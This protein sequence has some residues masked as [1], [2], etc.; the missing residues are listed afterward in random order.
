M[1]LT[2]FKARNH[3]QQVDPVSGP[4]LYGPRAGANDLI[5]DRATLPEWFAELH[6]R[7]SFT[8]DVAASASNTKLPRY[9]DIESNGLEQSWAGERVWCNPPFSDLKSWVAKASR[10]DADLIVMLVPANRT[11]Q[12][13]WHEHIE[14]FRDRPGSIL[15]TEF[16]RH[17]RRFI[18]QGMD[19]VLPNDRPPFGVCLLI[20]QRRQ[21]NG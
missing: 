19:G 18:R 8:V 11:E 1:G 15:T 9:Y 12:A 21:G 5:D 14:P 17:R 20:W 6:A 3:P 4:D 10:E 7:F 13:W 2:R 16:I